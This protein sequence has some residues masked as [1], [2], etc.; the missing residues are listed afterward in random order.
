MS[1]HITGHPHATPGTPPR[2]HGGQTPVLPRPG[3]PLR[4]AP[5]AEPLVQRIGRHGVPLLLVFAVLTPVAQ[6]SAAA[7]SLDPAVYAHY[8]TTL[9]YRPA[10]LTATFAM[11]ACCVLSAVFLAM[12]LI[13]GRGRWWALSGAAL[14]VLGAT[15]MLLSTGGV[16][17]RAER[18]RTALLHVNFAELNIDAGTTST[19]GAL[20]V[21]GGALVLTAGWMVLGVGLL[22]TRGANAADGI[23]L[24]ISAPM[25]YL[26]G[27]VLRVLPSMGAFV[28]LAAALGIV[29]TARRIVAA[30]STTHVHRQ[31]EEPGVP[32]ILVPA[33]P[34]ARR[35]RRRGR[36]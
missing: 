12:L 21:V 1:S 18:L 13:R 4:A 16:V 32:A 11:G 26:G 8:L 5:P 20:V 10:E 2:G 6:R 9:R 14:V 28:L 24:A 25:M 35:R 27:M 29:V 22:L 31:V 36:R 7:Y 30:D 3:A 19:G 15:M 34:E 17:I 23:L 33:G